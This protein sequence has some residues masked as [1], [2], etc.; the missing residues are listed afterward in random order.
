MQCGGQQ[1]QHQQQA[2]WPAEVDT[3]AEKF[4]L[5]RG[6]T[7]RDFHCH[8]KLHLRALAAQRV[9]ACNYAKGHTKGD[10]TLIFRKAHPYKGK[11]PLYVSPLLCGVLFM[12]SLSNSSPLLN[13]G[14]NL[15]VEN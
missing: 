8:D 1:Q 5:H 4:Q 9:H 11:R 10:A 2:D 13:S 15:F 14:Y 12:L 7:L 6:V 3:A